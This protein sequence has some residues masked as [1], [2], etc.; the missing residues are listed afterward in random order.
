MTEVAFVRREYWATGN[1]SIAVVYFNLI[2]IVRDVLDKKEIWQINKFIKIHNK[3]YRS[4]VYG[5]EDGSKAKKAK[6]D[7]EKPDKLFQFDVNPKWLAL[8]EIMT[9]IRKEIQENEVGRIFDVA[10]VNN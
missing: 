4:R 8:S 6:A 1:R 9:D 5:P 10:A 3:R 7:E 2:C